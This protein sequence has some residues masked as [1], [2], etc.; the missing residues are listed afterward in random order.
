MKHASATPSSR[1]LEGELHGAGHL[2]RI[3]PPQLRHV[4]AHA[5]GLLEV[6]AVVPRGLP[7]DELLELLRGRP[8]R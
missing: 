6:L 1:H 3:L 4:L 7:R 5:L 8:L 2:T